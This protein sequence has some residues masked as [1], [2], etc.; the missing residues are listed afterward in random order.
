MNKLQ[1]KLGP[2]KLWQWIAIGGAL[3]VALLILRGKEGGAAEPTGEVFGGTGTG[4]FGAIDPETGIPYSFEGGSGAGSAENPST[5]E[6]ESLDQF[7]E[8]IG[9]LKEQGLLGPEFIENREVVHDAEAAQTSAAATKQQ[10]RGNEGK[11]KKGTS[12]GS[13]ASSGSNHSAAPHPAIRAN[14]TQLSPAKAFSTAV[15]AAQKATAQTNT[16]SAKK[17]EKALNKAAQNVGNNKVVKSPPPK[18][19]QN[20]NQKKGKK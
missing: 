15:S 10:K 5:G 13:A 2:L 18:N 14:A 3:G 16:P 20:N 17:D 12:T 11:G 6:G 8:R 9:M 1:H 19:N 7:L 4:A